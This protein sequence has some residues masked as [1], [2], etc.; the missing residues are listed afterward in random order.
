DRL[1]GWRTQRRAAAQIEARAVARTLDL[2]TMHLAA[3]KLAAVVRA[4]VLDRV[5]L[6]VDI[7]HRDRGVAVPGDLGFPGQQFRL[8]ADADPVTHSS[9]PSFLLV[10]PAKAGIQRLCFSACTGKALDPDFRRDDGQEQKHAAITTLS[11]ATRTSNPRAWV[12]RS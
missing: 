1:V 3:G 9:R 2:E 7:E 12:C 5:Q 11:P 8:R 6:A 4:D 10:I